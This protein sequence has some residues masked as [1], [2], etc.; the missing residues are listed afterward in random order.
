[1]L[2]LIDFAGVEVYSELED[3]SN[4]K[5]VYNVYVESSEWKEYKAQIESSWDSMVESLSNMKDSEK[6]SDIELSNYKTEEV[7]LDLCRVLV[8][9]KET[10]SD[11]TVIE[12][13]GF[14]HYVLKT[15][16]GYKIIYAEGN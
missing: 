3:L 16:D 5:E 13:Q 11:G 4:C 14:E 8:D 1:M 7:S 12:S 15:D 10:N 9:I 6:S 2:E